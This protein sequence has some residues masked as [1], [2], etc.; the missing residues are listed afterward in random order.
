MSELKSSRPPAD[1]DPP[2]LR[3]A[4][5]SALHRDAYYAIYVDAWDTQCAQ[6]GTQSFDSCVHAG[7]DAVVTAATADALAGFTTITAEIHGPEFARTALDSLDGWVQPPS[8]ALPSVAEAYYALYD[9]AF[10]QIMTAPVEIS[11][12]TSVQACLDV[13][14]AAAGVEAILRAPAPLTPDLA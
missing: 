7:I 14:V 5:V 3:S 2:G 8:S 12:R 10:A 4:A 9:R 1:V 6:P 11:A 13:V